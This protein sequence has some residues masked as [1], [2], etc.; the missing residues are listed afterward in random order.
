MARSTPRRRAEPTRR[1]PRR[2]PRP[3]PS[4]A[5]APARPETSS[6]RG[7]AW[8]L[9]GWS[10]LTLAGVALLVVGV[11]E[12]LGDARFE[13]AAGLVV[14]AADPRL[15]EVGAVVVATTYVWALA[16]RTGG[17]PV[18]FSLLTLAIGVVVLA[19][20][21]DLLRRGAAAMTCVVSAVLAIVATVPGE[22]LWQAAREVL[23]AALV[24]TAGGLATVGLRPTVDVGRF[25]YVTLALGLLG[26]FGLIYRLGAGLHGLG[27]RGFLTVVVGAAVLGLTLAYAELLRRYGTPTLVQWLLDAADWLRATVGASPRPIVAL[28]GVPALVW[29]THMRAWRRQGWWVCAFGVGATVPF[30]QALL[31][32]TKSR[33]ESWL[34]MGYG[35]LVGLVLGAL[36]IRVDRALTGGGG[37]RGRRVV[38]PPVLRPEPARF[39]ALL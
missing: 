35:I 25:E 17:R 9:A 24:A 11:L 38:Q 12:P 26:A 32:P 29:G 39:E 7:S 23:V 15:S 36:V 31:D 18:V 8:L 34:A 2:K 3:A 13:L 16:A 10:L 4:G 19:T 21:Q 14:D 1:L 30:A 28:L 6:R 27:R 20:D 22:K 37:R 33:P 5:A